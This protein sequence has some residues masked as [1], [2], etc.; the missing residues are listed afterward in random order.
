MIQIEQLKKILFFEGLSDEILT[1]IGK[2]A[3]ITTYEE[4]TELF[5]QNQNLSKFYMLLSGK[6]FLNS[7]SPNGVSLTL[8]E[9]TEGRSFGLS[10][11]MGD[12]ESSFTAICAEQ[13]EVITIDNDDMLK[14]FENNRK[15]GYQI[16]LRVVQ[17]F[18]SRMNKHTQQFLQSIANH[19]EIKKNL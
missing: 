6:I 5:K 16:T 7:R 4:E 12:V 18:Q 3:T 17:L 2:I 14:L 13:S 15:L 1:E 19:P 9:V 10:A 11:I 8:D